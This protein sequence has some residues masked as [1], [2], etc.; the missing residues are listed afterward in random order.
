MFQFDGATVYYMP[1]TSGWGSTFGGL[2]TALWRP[3]AQTSDT[4]LGV[5][6]NRFGFTIDWASDKVLTVE[7]TTDLAH[8]SWAP[9]AAN[10]LNGGSSYFSDPHWTNYPAR[11]YR[12]R[13]P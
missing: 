6:T 4:A 7:A 13:S 12:L 10:T 1:G 2:Q 8:P 9:V 5:Q 11:F 3:Q